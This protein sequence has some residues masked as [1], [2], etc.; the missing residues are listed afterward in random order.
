MKIIVTGYS[1][2][3]ILFIPSPSSSLSKDKN[4]KSA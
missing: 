2:Q 3:Q 4:K 1:V